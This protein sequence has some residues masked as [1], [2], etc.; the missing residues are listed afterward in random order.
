VAPVRRID[1]SDVP[2]A[3]L[4]AE[5][6]RRERAAE[7][8]PKRWKWV[9]RCGNTVFGGGDFSKVFVDAGRVWCRVCIPNDR[10]VF[11]GTPDR[12]ASV[13]MEQQP[14]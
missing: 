14:A 12:P 11:Y 6:A 1:L 9:C 8:P 2:T 13:P 10:P 5:L 4:R 7:G 3:A